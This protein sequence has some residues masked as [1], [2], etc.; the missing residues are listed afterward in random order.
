[1]NAAIEERKFYS[2]YIRKLNPETK[3]YESLGR[4]AV[5]TGEKIASKFAQKGREKESVNKISVRGK[6]EANKGKIEAENAEIQSPGK[7]V[8]AKEPMR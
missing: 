5:D 7:E 6:L 4:Y 8:K 1:M 3:G 2:C